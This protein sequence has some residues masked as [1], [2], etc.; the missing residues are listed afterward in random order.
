MGHDFIDSDYEG[1]SFTLNGKSYNGYYGR[2]I[3]ELTG[4][5]ATAF[6]DDGSPAVIR[7]QTGKG[8][9]ITFNTYLWYSFGKDGSSATDVA[10]LLSDELKL[11]TVTATAPLTV[12]TACAGKYR[13]AFVFNYTDGEVSGHISGE[14]FDTDVTVDAQDVKVIRTEI[15]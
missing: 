8:E 1:L 13:Y 10:S 5:K 6:F 4:G 7:K 14:G 2:E 15:I 9:V 11:V 3:T 12:R